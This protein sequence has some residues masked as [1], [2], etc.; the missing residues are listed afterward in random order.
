LDEP[1]FGF[2]LG[3]NEEGQLV[4]G[5]VD[6]Q[7]YTGNFSFLPVVS[8]G[9]WEVPLE[10]VSVYTGANKTMSLFHTSRVI[11]DSG[12]SALVGPKDDLEAIAAMLKAFRFPQ[13]GSEIYVADCE[14]LVGRSV[15]F[16][17]GDREYTL[18]SEDLVVA[19]E[20]PLCALAL[21]PMP[22][23]R[24][25]WILGDAFMR[26]NY[27]LFDWGRKRVGLATASRATKLV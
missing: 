19:Q 11:V 20:G 6:A 2:Y 1:V 3:D 24:K 18:D 4:I 16:V 15:A 9:F 10:S 23:Q 5:G 7:H 25:V 26:K 12:T 8:P 13:L 27:V 22:M 21:Q 17:L 14:D